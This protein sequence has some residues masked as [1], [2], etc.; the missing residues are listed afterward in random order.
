MDMSPQ[1][2][3]MSQMQIMQTDS[4]NAFT[5]QQQMQAENTKQ[6]MR[7]WQIKS[8]TMTKTF[9]IEQEAT[10]NKAKTSD[11]MFQ[12]WNQYISS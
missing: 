5:I 7:G 10:V 8:D 1:T 3:A 2:M 9:E 11:K 12:K 4:M 6:M